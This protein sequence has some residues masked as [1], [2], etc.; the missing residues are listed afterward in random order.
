[1]STGTRDP[2]LGVIAAGAYADIILVNVKRLDDL[3]LVADPH[4]IIDQIMKVG[5]IYKNT[6]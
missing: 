3:D 4:A 5:R 1:M 2:I 6:N